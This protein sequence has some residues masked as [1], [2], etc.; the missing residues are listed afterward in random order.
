MGI[1][2]RKSKKGFTVIEAIISLVLFTLIMIPLGSFTLTAVKTSVK[3]ATKEQ[4]INA[5]Q[6][7]VES[8]KSLNENDFDKDEIDLPNNIKLKKEPNLDGNNKEASY[9]INGNFQ[10]PNTRNTF[11]IEGTIVPRDLIKDSESNDKSTTYNYENKKNNN[12]EKFNY[13]IYINSQ[14]NLKGVSSPLNNSEIEKFENKNT[15]K[16]NNIGKSKYLNLK[17]VIEKNNKGYIETC[18]NDK[19]INN[20][21]VKDK[22]EFNI[23]RSNLDIKV[24]YCGNDN[25][26]INLS[27]ENLNEN[28]NFKLNL[29]AFKLSNNSNYVINSNNL[30]GDIDIRAN[31]MENEKVVNKNMLY[32]IT[33]NVKKDDDILYTLK[34]TKAM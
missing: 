24:I 33:L 3:S 12:E 25:K 7:I 27:V 20:M 34:S 15:D 31:L 26:T 17:V 22:Y 29:S 1:K 11:N 16:I 18:L 6:S 10:I 21:D 23:G 32:H 4:A 30:F 19:T 5:A 14:G 28:K 2:K 8:I 13:Y 9:S